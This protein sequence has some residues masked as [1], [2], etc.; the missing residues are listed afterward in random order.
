MQHQ[1]NWCG[2]CTTVFLGEVGI[3]H[4]LRC[5]Q[6]GLLVPKPGPL[7]LGKLDELKNALRKQH[8]SLPREMLN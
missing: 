5:R 7:T 4:T 1:R 6:N 8:G 3:Q 2:R